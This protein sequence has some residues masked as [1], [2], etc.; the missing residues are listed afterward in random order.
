MSCPVYYSV[1]EAS[2]ASL[3]M[4]I[5]ADNFMLTGGGS[6][7]RLNEERISECA[8]AAG[9]EQVIAYAGYFYPKERKRLIKCS[10]KPKLTACNADKWIINRASRLFARGFDAIIASGDGEMGRAITEAAKRHDRSVNFYALREKASR[11][12]PISHFCEDWIIGPKP[13][14]QFW[15]LE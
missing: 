12:L 10:I 8:Q 13:L 7:R 5:D 14:N 6:R 9:A 4:L 1:S 2:E 11:S 3:V 15:R